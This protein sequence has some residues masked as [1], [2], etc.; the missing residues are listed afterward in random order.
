MG[1][2]PGGRS[3][4]PPGGRGGRML[5]GERRPRTQSR[6]ASV[7]AATDCPIY[8]FCSASLTWSMT[9]RAGMRSRNAAAGTW[10]QSPAGAGVMRRDV[11]GQQSPVAT[12]SSA[13][14]P[15]PLARMIWL[16]RKFWATPA[17]ALHRV[18][19][20]LRVDGAPVTGGQGG[21]AGRGRT[22]CGRTGCGVRGAGAGV[23]GRGGGR[24]GRRD[25]G[26]QLPAGRAEHSPTQIP[27]SRVTGS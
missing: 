10:R 27:D 16:K 21:G 13:S 24:E 25:L 9:H 15:V 23:A 19:R 12:A 3:G 5:N 17:A 14:S 1:M 26:R 11:R 7:R 4:T 18:S 2:G 20:M 6:P 8:S 22:G